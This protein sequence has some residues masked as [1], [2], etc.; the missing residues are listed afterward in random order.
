MIFIGEP[1]MALVIKPPAMLDDFPLMPQSRNKLEMIIDG[2]LP[3]PGSKSGILL[4]GIYG[5]GKTTMAKLLPGWL[6]TAKMTA[7][8]QNTAVGQLIDQEAPNY[9]INSCAQG[10]NGSTLMANIQAQTGYVSWNK[11]NLHYVILDEVDLLTPAASASLK[12]IMNRKDVIFILTTNHL[13]AIDRGVQDRSVLIDL[14]APPTLTWVQKIK[15]I[16]LDSGL[17]A[18]SDQAIS[19]IVQAGNGSARNILTDIQ[20][21]EAKRNNLSRYKPN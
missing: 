9:T 10:Q 21:A 18:P 17:A 5:T 1:V 12:S 7:D 8:L 14:N 15:T 19:G 3:V 13:N 4:Y 11:S 6:E 20:V 16:Y 2:T